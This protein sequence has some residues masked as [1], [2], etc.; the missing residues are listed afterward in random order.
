MPDIDAE[1]ERHEFLSWSFEPGDCAVFHA[2]S[3]HGA[4]GN[5][6]ATRRRRAYATRWTG[7][8]ATYAQ[9]TGE[10]SPRIADHGLS[11]GDPIGGEAFPLVWP[12]S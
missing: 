9:R 6:S 2:R 1:R 11:P 3:V 10:V 7:D 8:D 4:P 5:D 12:R